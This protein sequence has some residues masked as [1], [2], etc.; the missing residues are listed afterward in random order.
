MKKWQIEKLPA[1]KP[2]AERQ[3][4]LRAEIPARNQSLQRVVLFPKG[5][6]LLNKHLQKLLVMLQRH[7]V[8][9]E[10]VEHQNRLLGVHLLKKQGEGGDN[11][12]Y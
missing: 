12:C 4:L 10:P 1:G 5:K 8:T 6:H 11:G 9:E 2:R 3:R 7:Y